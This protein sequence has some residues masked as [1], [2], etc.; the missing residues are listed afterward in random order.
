MIAVSEHRLGEARQILRCQIQRWTSNGDDLNV[1]AAGLWLA[2]VETLCGRARAA[3]IALGAAAEVGMTRRF[4]M[5]PNWWMPAIV[6]SAR[7]IAGG[8]IAG[9]VNSLRVVRSRD[10]SRSMAPAIQLCRDG[11]ALV[12]GTSLGVEPWRTGRAGPSVLRRFFAALIDVYPGS[13]TRD[14]LADLLWPDSN[15]D[16]ARTNLYGATRDLRRVLAALP[17]VAVVVIDGHY[18]VQLAANVNVFS[19]PS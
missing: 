12:N 10:D 6:D 5:S 14:D 1:F 19:H 4:S 2:H 7:E 9:Y 15:W 11:T 16:H 13:I 17:G 8:E 18:G 3:R